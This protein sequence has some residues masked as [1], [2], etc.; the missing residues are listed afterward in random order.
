MRAPTACSCHR[1]LGLTRVRH[2]ANRCGAGRGRTTCACWPRPA[3]RASTRCTCAS[4]TRC[5]TSSPDYP[6]AAFSW[7]A[8]A[9][10]NPGLREALARS[11]WRR[12]GWHRSRGALQ[13]GPEDA[14][15]AY[16]RAL[17]ATGRPALRCSPPA[18]R[19]PRDAGGRHSPR[20][21]PKSSARPLPQGGSVAPRSTG[22]TEGGPICT[23]PH[24][25]PRWR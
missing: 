21:R 20:S 24:S 7:D 3:P 5:S 25:S 4:A 17:E 23:A 9:P 15:A 2:A 6:V 19:S 14:I 13:S 11:R 16:H 8:T 18:A 10:G 22:S 12:H 1:G